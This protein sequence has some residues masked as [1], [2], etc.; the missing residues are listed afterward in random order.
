MTSMTNVFQ[1]RRYK[2]LLEYV[3]YVML[4]LILS[5][6]AYKNHVY[7]GQSTEQN[8]FSYLNNYRRHRINHQSNTSD[9]GVHSEG[10]TY[11]T[12]THVNK[13]VVENE[14]ATEM[15]FPASYSFNFEKEFLLPEPTTD[16]IR[17]RTEDFDDD[18]DGEMKVSVN[19]L[20]VKNTKNT[21]NDNTNQINVPVKWP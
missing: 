9:G 7:S 15:V 12:S 14:Q 1:L 17:L 8:Q 6:L 21:V 19:I 2:Q 20:S 13:Q 11:N 4:T 16:T 18:V 3:S 10:H 5:T